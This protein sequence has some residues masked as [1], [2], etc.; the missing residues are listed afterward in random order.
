MR[1]EAVAQVSKAIDAALAV[2]RD[3]ANPDKMAALAALRTTLHQAEP[4]AAVAAMRQF[5]AGREDA[6]TGLGFKVGPNGVLVDAP[7]LRT[8]MMDQ[9]GIIS[10]QAGLADAAEAGRETLG[11]MTSSD[12]WALAMRNV[13]WADPSGSKA[14]LAGKVREMIAYTPWQQ[15]PSP[16]FLEA[17]DV[18]AYTGD[19][20]LFNDL[21][22][23]A[24]EPSAL[25]QAALRGDGPPQRPGAR[26]RGEL[27]ER[28]P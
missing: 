6:A 8:F 26:G 3:P 5:L 14:F 9:L 18:A 16:G 23:L 13:A 17:F 28:A 19:A 1:R 25:Q 12:E 27:S 24:R 11:A 7:T 20:S 22:P 21:A 10:G 4:A 15:Q 2:L